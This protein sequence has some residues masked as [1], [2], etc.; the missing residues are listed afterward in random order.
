MKTWIT[1]AIVIVVVLVA[2][3]ACSSN[4]CHNKGG[5]LALSL[6]NSAGYACVN[7]SGEVIALP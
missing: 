6:L 7:D 4:L 5:H 3:Y 2:F 1:T